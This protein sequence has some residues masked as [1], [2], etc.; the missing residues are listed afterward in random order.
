V[1]EWKWR[2]RE[3]KAFISQKILLVTL[4]HTVEKLLGFIFSGIFEDYFVFFPSIPSKTD[5]KATE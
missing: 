3:I 5:F 2:N 4:H 1:S